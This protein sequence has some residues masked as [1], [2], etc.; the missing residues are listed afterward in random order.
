MGIYFHEFGTPYGGVLVWG[1]GEG[2]S[3]LKFMEH[4]SGWV[5]DSGWRQDAKAFKEVEKQVNAFFDKKLRAFDLELAWRGS[6]FC[7]RVWEELRKLEYGETVSYGELARRMGAENSQRAVGA[8]LGKNAISLVVPCHRV[9]AADGGLGGYGGGLW[10]KEELLKL[11]EVRG[12]DG[13]L[14]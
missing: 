4:A 13:W 2:L 1:D 8:A 10:L 3:G 6:S 5:R 11:E 14:T 9:V 7:R 12:E